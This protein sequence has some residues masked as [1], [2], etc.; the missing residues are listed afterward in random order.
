MVALPEFITKNR[1]KRPLAEKSRWHYIRLAI[2]PRYFGSH[3]FQIKS[4]YGTLSG[5]HDRS[6]RIRY[7]K[8]PE[9]PLSGGLT[10]TSYPACNKTS[11]SWKPCYYGSLSGSHAHSFRIR[12]EKSPEEPPSGGLTMTSYSVGNKTSLSRKPCITVK[13]YYG[14]L[15]LSFGRLVILKKNS[16]CK[17]K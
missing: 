13:C 12:H 14:L 1:L 2:K 4:Y 6:F 5:S 3:A 16:K 17:F 11:L 7:E 15:S 10:M 8:S 9:T